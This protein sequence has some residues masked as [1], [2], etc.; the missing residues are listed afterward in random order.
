MSYDGEKAGGEAGNEI[1]ASSSTDDGVVGTGHSGAMISGHHQ[2][3]L[4]ELTGVPRQPKKQKCGSR[5][6]QEFVYDNYQGY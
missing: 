5:I 4:N 6:S 1:F 2:A 3:H